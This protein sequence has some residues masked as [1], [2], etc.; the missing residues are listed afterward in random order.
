MAG[1]HAMMERTLCIMSSNTTSLGG[2]RA[3][4]GDAPASVSALRCRILWPNQYRP[5]YSTV[6]VPLL[7]AVPRDG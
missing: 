3:T 1:I 7:L 4:G 2:Y 5:R 6:C